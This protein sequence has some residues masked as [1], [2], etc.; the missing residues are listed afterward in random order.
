MAGKLL[1]SGYYDNPS[2]APK[3]FSDL[4]L[5]C[6]TNWDKILQVDY[7]FAFAGCVGYNAGQALSEVAND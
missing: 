7:L 6:D 4:S 3:Y 2:V 5:I 1:I